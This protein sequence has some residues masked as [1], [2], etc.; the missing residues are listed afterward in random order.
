MLPKV[1]NADVAGMM[2]AI[3]EYLRSCHCVIRVSLEYIIIK[4]IIVQTYG[5]SPKFVT[6]DNEI[7]T[8]MLHSTPD[9]NRLHSE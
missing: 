7:I 5:D 2:E 9:K 4:T 1:N 8:R 6:S 3:R